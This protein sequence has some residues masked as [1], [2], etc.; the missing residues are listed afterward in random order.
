MCASLAYSVNKTHIQSKQ[1]QP[2]KINY[3]TLPF[4]QLTRFRQT[5]EYL[6]TH[7]THR[8]ETEKSLFHVS[9]K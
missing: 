5:I 1:E 9:R 6:V 7:S 4:Q 8:N 2:L 3:N